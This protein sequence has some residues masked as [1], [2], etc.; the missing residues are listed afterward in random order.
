[1]PG[2]ASAQTDVR[3]AGAALDGRDADKAAIQAIYDKAQGNAILMLPGGRWPTT[4][5]FGWGWNPTPSPGKYVL[6]DLLGNVDAGSDAKPGSAPMSA[7]GDGDLTE[8]F[9]D[10]HLNLSKRIL[11]GTPFSP[12]LVIALENHSR[13]YKP[14]GYGSGPDMPAL[15][16]DATSFPGST[17]QLNGLLVNLRAG[18]N[19][20]WSSEEQ[21]INVSVFRSGHNSTWAYNS[22]SM[23]TTGRAPDAFATLGSEIDIVANGPDE[24]ESAYDAAHGNRAFMFLAGK[25]YPA[26]TWT[27]DRQVDAGTIVQ[28]TDAKGARA[29]FVAANAGRTGSRAPPWPASARVA[30]GTV[31]WDFGEP[32]AST[33]GRVIWLDGGR[34][35]VHGGP[36]SVKYGS[37][38]ATDGV[39]QNAAIDLSLAGM[40]TS[41]S[42]AIR[43]GH[44]MPVDFS[45]DGTAAGRNRHV[46]EYASALGL[47]Y[48]IGPLPAVVVGDDFA[49]H[50]EGVT[51]LAADPSRASLAGRTTGYGEGGITIGDNLSHGRGETD[52]VVPPGGLD[53]YATNGHGAIGIPTLSISAERLT[54]GGPVLAAPLA[55]PASSHAPCQAGDREADK[56]FI[57]VCVAK[58]TWRRARLMDF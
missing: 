40:D 35:S 44:D 36:S 46:L 6:W 18:G 43:L 8:R 20:P 42:A 45:G 30:D 57:Y 22:L 27:A 28:A 49:F 37:G 33:Y 39:F 34:G 50:A 19:N 55:T 47:T 24:P 13:D 10:G 14:F 41:A 32:F 25:T 5:P 29:I 1:M 9:I 56:E 11:N 4:P 16:I 53:V 54:I 17:G 26:S 38:F 15:Q 52:L 48:R 31:V 21:G 23:D 7:I 12:D 51:Q 58:N 3:A 2:A